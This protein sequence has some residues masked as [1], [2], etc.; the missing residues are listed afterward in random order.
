MGAGQPSPGRKRLA[1][2]R[3]SHGRLRKYGLP[4]NC[5]T[6]AMKLRCP[7]RRSMR[8]KLC[9]RC[10]YTPCDL[11]DHDD[12]DAALSLCAKCDGEYHQRVIRR[13]GTCLTTSNTTSVVSTIE[14]HAAPFA[15][16]NSASFATIAGVPSSV[17]RNAST[18]SRPDG[19]M[20]AD[21]C[22]KFGAPEKEQSER[23]N[24][25]PPVRSPANN[26]TSDAVFCFELGAAT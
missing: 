21:G 25:V 11:A 23:R 15:T 14:L 5:T 7:G 4:C 2:N 18:T 26:S 22:G 9:A 10:P 6:T 3:Q 24:L 19:R 20:T 16:E 17:Q 12:S 8:V 1:R 13:R